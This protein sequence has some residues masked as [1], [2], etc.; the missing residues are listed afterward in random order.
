M[1]EIGEGGLLGVLNLRSGVK[2]DSA[3]SGKQIEG[4]SSKLR[5]ANSAVYLGRT[6][7]LPIFFQF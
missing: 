1:M 2:Q 5:F 3:D 6:S 4:E 7:P